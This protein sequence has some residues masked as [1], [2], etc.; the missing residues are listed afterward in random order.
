M[1]SSS[2]MM[3]SPRVSPFTSIAS[4]GSHQ[5]GTTTIRCCTNP[6]FFPLPLSKAMHR[7]PKPSPWR[8]GVGTFFSSISARVH[9]QGFPQL[10]VSL[11][12]PTTTHRLNFP[13]H[14]MIHLMDGRIKMRARPSRRWLG[15]VRRLDVY[16]AN[17]PSPPVTRPG[18]AYLPSVP[19]AISPAVPAPSHCSEFEAGIQP[20][21]SKLSQTRKDPIAVFPLPS[22][23]R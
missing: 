14:P 6:F 18:I 5:E 1:A 13:V 11:S 22:S 10:A 12:I 8:V 7:A 21:S 19:P 3:N 16:V 9:S 23:T 20:I 15:M 4:L 17:G 2:L